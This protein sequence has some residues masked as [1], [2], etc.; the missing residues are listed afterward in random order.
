MNLGQT[1]NKTMKMAT[2]ANYWRNAWLT[3]TTY[4]SEGGGSPIDENG[5]Q[6][7]WDNR[8]EG[9]CKTRLEI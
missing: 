5:M 6:I 1:K 3:T 7:Y 2:Y 8:D 9:V 4:T